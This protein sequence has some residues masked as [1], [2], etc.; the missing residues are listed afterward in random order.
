MV[1]ITGSHDSL[2]SREN[3]SFLTSEHEEHRVMYKAPVLLQVLRP[4]EYTDVV[5]N[6]NVELLL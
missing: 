3:E 6:L 2:G 5:R 4:L 1:R